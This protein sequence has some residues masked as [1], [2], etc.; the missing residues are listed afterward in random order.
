[1]QIIFYVL[2]VIGLWKMFEKAHVAGWKALIPVYST[3]HK[4]KIANRSLSFFWFMIS[5]FIGVFITVILWGIIG[6]FSSILGDT[7]PLITL[8]SDLVSRTVPFFVGLFV[9]LVL[10][11][12]LPLGIILQYDIAKS[13]GKG[14]WMTVGL[15]LVPFICNLVLGYGKAEYKKIHRTKEEQ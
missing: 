2:E 6:L 5:P 9:I 13:F 10:I 15:V 11:V 1:M 12:T 3:Y 7:S 14:A 8:F 4:V